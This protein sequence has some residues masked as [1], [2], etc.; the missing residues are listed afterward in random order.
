MM[1]QPQLFS[2]R[3]LG[4]ALAHGHH[5]DHDTR[6]AMSSPFSWALIT[7]LMLYCTSLCIL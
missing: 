6:H 3:V 2:C 7:G 1:L 4:V 5:L